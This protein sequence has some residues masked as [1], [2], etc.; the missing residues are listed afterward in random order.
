MKVKSIVIILS[1][2]FLAFN[3]FAQAENESNKLYFPHVASNTNWETEICVINQSDEELTGTFE[4]YSR[5]GVLLSDRPETIDGLGRRAL[6][7]GEEFSS[8]ADIRYIVFSTESSSLCGYTKFYKEGLYR[9]AVPAVK[10]INAGDIYV[11]HIASNDNW[12]TGLALVNTTDSQKT[13]DI[14]F[15]TGQTGQIEMAPGEHWSDNIKSFFDGVAQDDI[16]SAVIKGGSGVIG[17]E[18]FS[19]GKTLS[20]VLLKD[21]T[22]DTLYFPHVAQDENWWTG[23]A[24]YN[25][26]N[27]E[28]NLT[29]IPYAK[30]GEV[31]PLFSETIPARGKYLGNA[32]QLRLPEGTEWF[33]IHSSQPLNGFELF[34]TTDGNSLGGY[35]TVNISQQA[36]IFPKLEN[37]GWTGV[38]FVN[39][40]DNESEVTLSIHDDD[41]FKVA[42][43]SI[44]LAGNE[45]WANTPED[46]FGGTITA[47]TYMKFSSDS[48]V[49]GFQLNRSTDKMF[50]DALSAANVD[51]FAVSSEKENR[52]DPAK[53]EDEVKFTVEELETIE[54]KKGRLVQ[55]CKECTDSP[56]VFNKGPISGIR[57]WQNDEGIFAIQLSYRVGNDSVNGELY[58]G[59]PEHP[60]HWELE[61]VFWPVPKGQQIVRIEGGTYCEGRI[62]ELQFFTKEDHSKV[63]GAPHKTES[64]F[65]P[66]EA[67]D[68]SGGLMTIT[69]WISEDNVLDAYPYQRQMVY[70][71]A[72]HFGPPCYIEGDF[73][74][75]LDALKN[76][77]INE[78]PVRMVAQEM[79]NKTTLIQEMNYKD[80]KEV[81]NRMSV[82][83]SFEVVGEVEFGS[84][85]TIG[86]PELGFGSKSKTTV[87]LS[88]KT[89]YQEEYEYKET[90]TVTWDLPVRVPPMTMVSALSTY[91]EY[92]ATIPFAYTL[93]WY[94]MK[95]GEKEI[96]KR[97]TLGGTYEGIEVKDF[98]H[99]L[100]EEPLE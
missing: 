26:S 33:K 95:N 27:S 3:G 15:S 68:G 50:L 32:L 86:I 78:I 24:A 13:L 22:T 43:K 64:E 25:P 49:V 87:K 55:Y 30:S 47:A 61:E 72:F 39:T 42:E 10:E 5:N 41:G 31:L 53:I 57:I 69:S 34:G 48:N 36:G 74:Y 66:V 40:S 44:S 19:K 58:R 82:K 28:A 92:R 35:S 91:K 73:V 59:F 80:E 81:T 63:F 38:A 62:S 77:S 16:K 45:K 18:L 29:V 37:D 1:V 83:F 46:L 84:E 52:Y 100:T 85:L 56:E 23:I 60:S 54:R 6:I 94:R 79:P 12:W 89:G 90:R 97:S 93:A 11:P 21:E 8:P 99:E 75:D 76:V 4:L 88:L 17:L 98:H 20:G 7:V 67:P 70:G 71:M 96:I 14:Q 9:V 2:I 65:M 51:S